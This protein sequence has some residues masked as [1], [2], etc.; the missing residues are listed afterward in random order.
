[1]LSWSWSSW[2][3]SSLSSLLLLLDIV[4]SSSEDVTRAM[5]GQLKRLSQNYPRGN[6]GNVIYMFWFRFIPEMFSALSATFFCGRAFVCFSAAFGCSLFCRLFG[7]M[8]FNKANFNGNGNEYNSCVSVRYNSL[9]ISLPLLTKNYKTT[10]WNS[11]I[12]QDIFE[13]TW[14]IRRPIF[15]ISLSNFKAVL[16]ILF[17]IF[18][19]V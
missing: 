1:M 11:H 2:S 8:E 19:T 18:L 4:P 10:T 17:G 5:H 7:F 13:R 15:K 16:H 3:S 9:F 6:G 14:T 12:L